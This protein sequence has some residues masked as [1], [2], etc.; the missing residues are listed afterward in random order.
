MQRITKIRRAPSQLLIKVQKHPQRHL[1]QIQ[2][3]HRP[4]A[5]R[6]KVKQVEN[7][8]WLFIGRTGCLVS[9][10]GHVC[11]IALPSGFA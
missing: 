1:Q 2:V 10:S 9:S 7:I 5:Q 3:A 6:Q 4:Q 11:C 8:A